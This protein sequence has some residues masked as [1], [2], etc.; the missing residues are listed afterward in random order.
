[1]TLKGHSIVS[2][3]LDSGL[4]VWNLTLGKPENTT[5]CVYW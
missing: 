4:N 5:E 1:M 3:N 2:T